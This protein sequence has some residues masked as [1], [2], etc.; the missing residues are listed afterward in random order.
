MNCTE[1]HLQLLRMKLKNNGSQRL[2]TLVLHLSE[3]CQ[4]NCN[5]CEPWNYLNDPFLSPIMLRNA[6]KLNPINIIVVGGGEPTFFPNN[7]LRLKELYTQLLG[8]DVKLITNGATIPSDRLWYRLFN[9]VRI[10]LDAGTEVTY[11]KIK[12]KNFFSK[13]INNLKK[14][15]DKRIP[16]V[17]VSYVVFKDNVYDIPKLLLLIEKIF[18]DY[19]ILP[20]LHFKPIR[21]NYSLLPSKD[22]VSS[23]LKTLEEYKKNWI[24]FYLDNFTNVTVLN[25]CYN[26]IDNRVPSSP[27]CYVSILSNTLSSDGMLFTCGYMA[28]IKKNSIGNLLK[29][30][31]TDILKYQMVFFNSLEP[32]NEKLCIGC[33]D[34]EMNMLFFHA[35]IEDKNNND[36]IKYRIG[37]RESLIYAKTN[38]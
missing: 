22:A 26:S 19:K 32:K 15:I 27:R 14:Y 12:G 8:K 28:R 4:L 34:D 9:S 29:D 6:L 37:H 38:R 21:G 16:S 23:V 17:G 11:N 18:I 3:A 2:A 33:C 25:K 7:Q 5:Y 1:S 36:P 24:S 30:S 35:L 10:S 13:V 20:Y 31:V